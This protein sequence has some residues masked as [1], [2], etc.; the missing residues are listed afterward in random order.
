[1][2]DE[3]PNE[4][5]A[6]LYH[7][8]PHCHMLLEIPRDKGGTK[9]KCLKCGAVMLIP[10]AEPLSIFGKTVNFFTGGRYEKYKES[11]FRQ[12]ADHLRRTAKRITP[13][14]KTLQKQ[15]SDFEQELEET[16]AILV[17]RD[18]RQRLESRSVDELAE[19]DSVGDATIEKLK[20]EGVDNLSNLAGKRNILSTLSHVTQAAEDNIAAY[21]DGVIEVAKSSPP[22]LN[23]ER[24]EVQQLVETMLSV[25][26][27]EDPLKRAT[28]EL[29]RVMGALRSFPRSSLT[30]MFMEIDPESEKVL[31][32]MILDLEARQDELASTENRQAVSYGDLSQADYLKA[33]GLIQ[34]RFFE[35]DDYLPYNAAHAEHGHLKDDLVSRIGQFELDL[36]GLKD[37]QLRRYQEFGTKFM[38]VRKHSFLGDEMGLGKTVQV[39]ASI[40]HLQSKAE[41]IWGLVIVPASLRQNWE[42]EIQTKTN[43]TAYVLEGRTLQKDALRWQEEGGIAIISYTTLRA[44]LDEMMEV[45]KRL[46][47]T[48]ADEAQYIK[49]PKSGRTKATR[50]FTLKAEYSIVMTGTPIENHPGEFTCILEAL[51]HGMASVGQLKGNEAA[52]SPEFFRQVMSDV[53]LRRNKEDVLDELPELN[54]IVEYVALEESDLRQHLGAMKAG[55][56]FM[57]LRQHAVMAGPGP[58]SKL[59]RV[60][61]LVE[62]YRE[63]AESVVVFSYFKDALGFLLEAIPDAGMIDGSVKS[64]DR[65]RLIDEF[66]AYSERG[67]VLLTQ[68]VAGG[69]G[70]NMQA[71][72]AVILVEPQLNPAIEAQA[73][74][75]VHRM[76]QRNSVNVHRLYSSHTIE[77]GLVK[78]LAKKR[79]Y[80]EDY[81]RDSVLK[82]QVES[83]VSNDEISAMVKEQEER[84]TEML[85]A[86]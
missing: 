28:D 72:S 22:R 86:E 17:R 76:G 5:E 12:K 53:Y 58:G 4:A 21:L 2:T 26:S 59:E 38:L 57:K 79:K 74:A 45:T 68:I 73:I 20:D 70:L 84:L 18:L 31:D 63:N 71:A 43:A 83:A 55:E 51:N 56:H 16:W 67:G 7:S 69:V 78:L 44:K 50:A 66:S 9:G 25:E 32:S 47:I 82:D 36:S 35:R 85:K 75:R 34:S 54:E 46:T 14:T 62:E 3:I 1:L 33:L 10:K 52:C 37:C 61:E 19:L 77:E 64:E 81:A 23:P 8:C 15:V 27:I 80:M 24:E 11:P 40:C 30:G 13:V 29:T 6:P 49:N 42:R 48:T 41:K 39:L 60:I 65:M